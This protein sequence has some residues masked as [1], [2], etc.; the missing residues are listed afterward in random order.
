MELAGATDVWG[1]P[2][3]R[4]SG[5]LGHAPLRRPSSIRRTMALEATWPEGEG[6]V[7]HITGRARDVFTPDF[8]VGEELPPVQV[9]DEAE[10]RTVIG[11]NRDIQSI[12]ATPVRSGIDNLIGCRGGGHLR[13]AI[14]DHLPEERAFGTDLYLLLDDLAGTTLVAPFAWSRW[15]PD[16]LNSSGTPTENKNTVDVNISKMTEEERATRI[17]RMENICIGFATG[18]SSLG[19][20]RG[21]SHRVQPV[22]SLVNPDDPDGWHKLSDLPPQSFRRA[23]RIDVWL[24][25]ADNDTIRVDAMFQ[26]SAGDPKV[27]RVAIH[28]YSYFATASR[29]SGLLTSIGADPRILP[30]LECPNAPSNLQWLVGTPIAEM[31]Q[32]VLDKLARTNGCTHLNDAC[33]ALAEV[34]VLASHLTS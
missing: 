13:L 29:S 15:N 11:R 1:D 16:W 22:V 5:P 7:T 18:S 14:Q 27:G 19:A 25:P 24:D 9:V 30:F 4:V 10:I 23:R 20:E 31:R 2:N 8:A 3:Q 32:T 12:S 26:D 6:G 33:R 34:P 21:N 17:A 28:E